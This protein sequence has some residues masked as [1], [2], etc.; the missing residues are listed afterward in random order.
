MVA[1]IQYVSNSKTISPYLTS[2]VAPLETIGL[3]GFAWTSLG[4]DYGIPW[5]IIPPDP[6]LGQLLLL[7]VVMSYVFETTSHND[8]QEWK[9]P[10]FIIVYADR[11]NDRPNDIQYSNSNGK[12]EFSPPP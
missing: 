6:Y 8:K 12:R 10:N 9:P 5:V 1:S 3:F 2:I 7:F 4:P 11:L